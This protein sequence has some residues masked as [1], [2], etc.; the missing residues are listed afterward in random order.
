MLILLQQKCCGR[1]DNFRFQKT[2][3]K[4]TTNVRIFN[5]ITNILLDTRDEEFR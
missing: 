1:R 5:K 3:I 4:V 2:N